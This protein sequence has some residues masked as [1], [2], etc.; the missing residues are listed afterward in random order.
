MSG[1]PLGLVVEIRGEDPPSFHLPPAFVMS[2]AAGEKMDSRVLVENRPDGGRL[3]YRLGSV[4]GNPILDETFR[5]VALG[6]LGFVV[7]PFSSA[8]QHAF[9]VCILT[10]LCDM[11]GA[12]YRH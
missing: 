12:C 5:C 3:G 7:P 11:S 8:V 2:G 1:H 10:S 6:A 9:S 4:D